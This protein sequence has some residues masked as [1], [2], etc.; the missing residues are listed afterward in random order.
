M[1]NGK[2]ARFYKCAKELNMKH[3]RALDYLRM[4]LEREKQIVKDNPEVKESADYN[5][6][7]L[8]EMI[9]ELVNLQSNHNNSTLLQDID[10]KINIIN[11]KLNNFILG[12]VFFV[13][14]AII[15]LLLF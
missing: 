13:L 14:G 2:L 6:K 1:E 8:E 9:L 5:I 3:L 10:E 12:T 15:G 4:E 11:T 7:V